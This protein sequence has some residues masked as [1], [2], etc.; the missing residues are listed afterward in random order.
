ME[1]LRTKHPDARPPSAESLDAYPN[2]P[3][4][5]VPVNITDDVV[6]A[7]AG[8]LSKEAGREGN[9]S[10]SLQHWIIRFG[11]ASRKLRLIVAVFGEW[12][13]NGQPPWAAYCAMMSGRLIALEKCPGIRP[14][15][16]GETWRRLLAKCLLRVTG[17]EAKAA[18]DTEQLAGGVE[19]GI[20]GAIHSMRLLWEQH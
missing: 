13:C 17:Q 16:I 8:S 14:V 18:C 4:E 2:N 20:E 11:A 19:A 15:G 12:L 9:D 1:V 3:P 7:V 6:R 10:V 5:M